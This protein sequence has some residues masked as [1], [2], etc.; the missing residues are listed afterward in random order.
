VDLVEGL[1]VEHGVAKILPDDDTLV[2]AWRAA[3]VQTDVDRAVEAEVERA[4][5]RWKGINPPADI[6]DLI[7]Q[8]LEENPLLSWDE[9]VA[10]IE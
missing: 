4:A 10:E 9:V 7:R 8:R 6:A 2:A 5:K 3:Q 1:L